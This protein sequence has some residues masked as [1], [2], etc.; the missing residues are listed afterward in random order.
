MASLIIFTLTL[1]D[2]LPLKGLNIGRRSLRWPRT[3]INR[4]MRRERSC[5]MKG[6]RRKEGTEEGC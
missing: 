6:D 3:R 5:L 1:S 4:R 2:I